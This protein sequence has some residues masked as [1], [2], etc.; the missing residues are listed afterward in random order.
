MRADDRLLGNALQRHP[1]EQGRFLD[2]LLPTVTAPLL[3]EVASPNTAQ[4]KTV[5]TGPPARR[6][7][8]R[9]IGISDAGVSSGVAE[10]KAT[11]IVFDGDRLG[12]RT[13]LLERRR[14]R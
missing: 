2:A 13:R 11:R 14:Q 9:V 12:R 8:V 7:A 10:A 6:R 3:L 4:R 1:C 5:Q